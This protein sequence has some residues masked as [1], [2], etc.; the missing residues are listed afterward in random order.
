MKP[1]GFYLDFV[2]VI[3]FEL[4]SLLASG[5]DQFYVMGILRMTKLL[6]LVRKNI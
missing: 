2:T 6:R 1:L 5:P 4:L 3:P